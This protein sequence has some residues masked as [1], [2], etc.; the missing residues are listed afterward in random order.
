MNC[1]N[2]H[3]RVDMA[4]DGMYFC[5]R[6][7]RM[8]SANEVYQ[9]PQ[10]A[11]QPPQPT[12]MLDLGAQVPP[13]Q[14]QPGGY[15]NPQQAP[16]PQQPNGAPVGGQGGYGQPGY[17]QPMNGQPFVQQGGY[18][19]PY[20]QYQQQPKS[21]GN[22]ASALVCGILSVFFGMLGCFP[23]LAI[24][25]LSLGITAMV[26]GKNKVTPSTAAFVLG[27][28]GTIFSGFM[29]LVVLFLRL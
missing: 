2:C 11:S 14:P 5:A 6:C 17:G 13:P 25:G 24:I 20:Q 15:Q 10:P 16:Y 21:T 18:P 12:G 27:L 29:L 26:Q 19:N 23:L 4:G 28:I 9:E 7:N 3:Q 22:S 8:L 1:R